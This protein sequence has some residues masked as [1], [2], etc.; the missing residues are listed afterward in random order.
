MKI[1]IILSVFFS[2][3]II[4]GSINNVVAYDETFT[5]SPGT[6]YAKILRLE[7]GDSI[8]YG[9]RIDGGRNDD[10]DFRIVDPYGGIFLDTTAYSSFNSDFI[11]EKTGTYKFL[12]DNKMSTISKKSIQFYWEITKPVL[13]I[14]QSKSEG[15]FVFGSEWLY[16]VIIAI[17]VIGIVIGVAA[18]QK[19]KH[20]G[21]DYSGLHG[22]GKDDKP[23]IDTPKKSF[24]KKCGHIDS[25]I[26]ED[27]MEIC[28]S[29]G[30][31]LGKRLRKG[32]ES[33]SKENQKPIESQQNLDSYV[34]Q[35]ILE[36][37]SIENETIY[38]IER[39]E[40]VLGILKDRLAK[41]EIS[42]KEFQE[43]KKELS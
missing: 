21:T 13:G 22:E 2:S 24:G 39:N 17:I 9:I 14:S 26:R 3:L 42:I 23:T 11:A 4:F 16:I 28:S 37:N 5:V 36:D 1:P 34:D 27:R 7:S 31:E 10:I 25:W 19:K 30:K 35:S 29:C 12:L 8:D 20:N 43:I 32:N 6:V 15:G 18:N 41:G 40:E 33:E 38:D